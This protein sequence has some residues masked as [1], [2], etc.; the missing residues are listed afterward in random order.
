MPPLNRAILISCWRGDEDKVDHHAVGTVRLGRYAMPVPAKSASSPQ[1]QH[2]SDEASR[3]GQSGEGGPRDGLTYC[4]NLANLLEARLAC[5]ALSF[6]SCEALCL[7]AQPASSPLELLVSS[8]T[9]RP[10]RM[11]LPHELLVRVIHL[12]T[13]P[14]GPSTKDERKR[15]RHLRRYALVSS[16]W[17]AAALDE[18]APHFFVNTFSAGWSQSDDVAFERVMH[19]KQRADERTKSVRTLAIF[20]DKHLPAKSARTLLSIFE[21]ATEMS[22]MQMRKPDEL[23]K[24]SQYVRTLRL[25][26]IQRAN[27]GGCYSVLTRLVLDH[28]CAEYLPLTLTADDFPALDTLILDIKRVRHREQPVRDWQ[29]GTRPPQ[30]RALC[31]TGQEFGWYSAFFANSRLE[32][33]HMGEQSIESGYLSLLAFLTKPLI[34]FSA[35]WTTA[36]LL[37]TIGAP[38]DAAA[39]AALPAFK[40]LVDLRIYQHKAE[41]HR[42]DWFAK[43]ADEMERALLSEGRDL[44]IRMIGEKLEA[45]EW[46]PLHDPAL[47]V[48]PAP[49]LA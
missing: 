35:D 31:L 30:V 19:A 48:V 13:P 24:G 21:R 26:E 6:G 1:S 42:E 25:I 49:R 11:S 16:A 45:A 29:E 20:G 5:R 23:L 44:R 36:P 4:H 27:F 47:I 14:P 39:C 40:R 3:R 7:P 2:R 8:P 22:L 17:H 28:C 38:L 15:R 43:F 37:N 18:A 10:A 46:D 41:P 34:S 12:A 33:L 9:A 32:H